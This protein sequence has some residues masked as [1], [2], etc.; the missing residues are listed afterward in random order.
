MGSFTRITGTL[1]DRCVFYVTAHLQNS[2]K[3]ELHFLLSEIAV[4]YSPEVKYVS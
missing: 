2:G 1:A 3:V 4:C